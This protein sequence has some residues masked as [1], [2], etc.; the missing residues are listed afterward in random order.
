MLTLVDARGRSA[1][2]ADAAD[3]LAGFPDSCAGDA[4]YVVADAR[5]PD[6]NADALRLFRVEGA[7][8]VAM[9]AS[10]PLPGT[11]TTLWS[12]PAGGAATAIVHDINAGRYEAFHVS[13]SCAR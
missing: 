2:R 11:L 10:T 1:A 3:H 7:H 13:L 6:A 9:P 5:A 12:A 4:P 8:L